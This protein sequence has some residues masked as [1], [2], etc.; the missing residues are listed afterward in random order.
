MEGGEIE[1]QAT[2]PK[3]NAMNEIHDKLENQFHKRATWKKKKS[4]AKKRNKQNFAFLIVAYYNE[5]RRMILEK[6][7]E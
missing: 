1:K 5:M 4:K 2:K 3:Q 6:L 7:R